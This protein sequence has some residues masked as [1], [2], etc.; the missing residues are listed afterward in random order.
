MSDLESKSALRERV[1][2][3]IQAMSMAERME[4]SAR[5]Q[6]WLLETPE[7]LCARTLLV[8]HSDRNEVSTHEIVLACLAEKKRV[9]LP[10]TERDTYTFQAREIFDVRRDLETSRFGS[11]KEPMS[12]LPSIAPSQIDLAI[13]PGRVFDTHGHRLGRGAG[14]Y[15]RFLGMQEVRAA[16]AALAF[17][18][19][20]LD[21]VPREAHDHPMDLIVTETRVIRPGHGRASTHG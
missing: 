4:R 5:A 10:R 15:D 1:L 14:Y 21:E 2:R 19:Q 13:V 7:F 20:V 8:Y 9:S 3:L 11:F 6:A 16:A 18:C 17:D 12:S